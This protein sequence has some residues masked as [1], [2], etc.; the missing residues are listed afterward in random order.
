MSRV[1]KHQ[2]DG[3]LGEHP[4]VGVRIPASDVQQ[5]VQRCR[6]AGGRAGRGPEGGEAR[7]GTPDWVTPASAPSLEQPQT[8]T[9]ARHAIH[10]CVHACMSPGQA[11]PTS[12]PPQSWPGQVH[13]P[14]SNP[15]L[16]L[17]LLQNGE[18]AVRRGSRSHQGNDHDQCNS[19]HGCERDGA[20][21]WRGWAVSPRGAE[22][23]AQP[24]RSSARSTRIHA[25]P[26]IHMPCK[27]LYNAVEPAQP[28][29]GAQSALGPHRIQISRPVPLG[30]ALC[31]REGS[32][33]LQCKIAGQCY[34]SR[35]C[36][37]E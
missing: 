19:P 17:E 36:R 23:A 34:L 28:P 13:L 10:A 33:I 30:Q 7:V 12:P 14:P 11:L 5:V 4:A 18:L 29:P 35:G 20:Q 8:A 27:S 15:G 21:A 25:Q 37:V 9:R 3:G 1:L 26:N 24:G 6:R 22:A 2:G 16:T 31:R 32:R